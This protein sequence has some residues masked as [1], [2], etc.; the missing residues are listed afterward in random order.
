MMLACRLA[1]FTSSASEFRNH[2]PGMNFVKQ[3]LY[4]QTTHC[5]KLSQAKKLFQIETFRENEHEII[6]WTVQ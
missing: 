1:E 6:Q 5:L 3:S 2:V 4:A